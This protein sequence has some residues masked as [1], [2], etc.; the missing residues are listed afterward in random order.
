MNI[1]TTLPAGDSAAWIDDPVTLADGRK[2]DAVGGWAL[3]YALRGP[4]SLDLTAVASGSSWST[5]IT[6][7]QSAALTPG[8]YSW[9]AVLSLGA[10]RFTVA[11]GQLTITRDLASVTGAFDGR[12]QAQRA[13]ADCETAMATF[14]NTGGRVKKYEIAGRSMEFQTIADLMTLRSFWQAKVLNEQASQSVANGLG[15][16]R[17]LF[18]RFQRP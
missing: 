16:P 8:L 14:N 18:V 5:A 13:L 17:N 3:R 4:S 7:S 1:C 6:A 9:A 10:E 11:S 12:S 2:A 15:N